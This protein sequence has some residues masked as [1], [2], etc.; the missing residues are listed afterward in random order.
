MLP[1]CLLVFRYCANLQFNYDYINNEIALMQLRRTLLL[2]Y[3][4]SYDYNHLYF[5]ANERNFY[6]ELVNGHLIQTPGT[7][8]IL[9]DIDNLHFFE[10][11]NCISIEY[12]SKNK[13]YESCLVKKQGLYLDN[14]SDCDD[15]L[16]DLID[17]NVC[18]FD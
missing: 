14:F 12:E 13:K 10:N 6:L 1:I 5:N 11:G 17:D 4:V 15:D 3:D 2:S 8:I 9:N 7:Q 18:L 16:D